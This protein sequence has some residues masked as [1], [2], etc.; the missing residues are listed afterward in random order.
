MQTSLGVIEGYYGKIFEETK[1]LNF[2]DFLAKNHYSYYIYAPKNDAFLRRQ[3]KDVFSK[4]ELELLKAQSNKCKSLGLNFG[5]GIS[6]LAITEDVD[7]NL[8]ILLDKVKVAVEEIHCNIIAILFDDIKLYTQDEGEKQKTIVNKVRL[9]LDKLIPQG[10][11]IRLIFCPTYYSFDAI[12]DKVFGPRP[13][14]YF[15][16]I[17]HKLLDNI[18]IFWTGNKVLSKEITREDLGYINQLLGRKVTL[19]DNYPVNDGKFICKHVYTREFVNRINLDGATL[20]HA[21]NPM[22]ECKLNEVSLATLPL[23]YRRQ[24]QTEVKLMRLS[25][26]KELFGNTVDK[27]IPILDKLSDFGIEKLSDSEIKALTDFVNCIDTEA[28]FELRQFLS[29]YYQFDPAC[30]TS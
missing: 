21:V 9:Y 4:E 19:W 2:F 11:K 20:S 16:Q 8:S 12:L 18:E 10:K 24:S 14:N 29:G 17:T 26:L 27:I 23:L 7:T 25:K 22:L 28:S 1:R 15:K 30:L 6:P 3:W 5:I 13:E